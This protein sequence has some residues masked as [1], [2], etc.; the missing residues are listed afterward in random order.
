[1]TK[2]KKKWKAK[3]ASLKWLIT[4]LTHP[5]RKLKK[6]PKDNP[7]FWKLTLKK[8]SLNQFKKDKRLQIISRSNWLLKI[9]LLSNSSRVSSKLS[10][11]F[12]TKISKGKLSSL[13]FNNFKIIIWTFKTNLKIRDFQSRHIN[14]SSQLQSSTMPRMSLSHLIYLSETI[15]QT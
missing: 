4:L 15:S 14:S 6:Q 1:M 3:T 10:Q 12:K 7:M 5:R 9:I 2:T 13:R 8:K 11:W